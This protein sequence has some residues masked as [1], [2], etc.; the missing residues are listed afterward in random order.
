VPRRCLTQGLGTIM[1]ARHVVLVAQGNRKADAVARVCEGPVTTMC[2]GSMLQLHKQATVIV[3][4]GAASRLQLADY[5][6]E[7]FAAKPHWQRFM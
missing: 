6:K 4:E 2:P 3:D 1:R 7:T 5:Y